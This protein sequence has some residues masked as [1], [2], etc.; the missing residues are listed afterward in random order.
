[1]RLMLLPLLEPWP[2]TLLSSL[3][4]ELVSMLGP[5][6]LLLTSALR[7]PLGPSEGGAVAFGGNR[8]HAWKNSCKAVQAKCPCCR[9]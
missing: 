2:M 8:P 9:T 3:L 1:M 7:L 5:L 6:W 4:L